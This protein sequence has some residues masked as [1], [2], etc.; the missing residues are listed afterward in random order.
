M[1]FAGCPIQ[2]REKYVEG[3]LEAF[4]NQTYP[5]KDIHMCFLVNDSIDG[6]LNKLIKYK[7]DHNFGKFTIIDLTG[8]GYTDKPGNRAINEYKQIARIRNIWLDRLNTETHI[9]SVDSDIIIPKNTLERLIAHKLDICSLL[10]NNSLQDGEAYNFIN[11][12][13][14]GL[15]VQRIRKPGVNPV[16]LTGAAYLINARVIR[17][18]VRYGGHRRGEDFY[19]CDMAHNLGFEVYCDMDLEGQH[20]MEDRNV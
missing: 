18:G 6:T 3:Y 7:E 17:A 16:F 14:R 15:L 19:F 12:N 8:F 1:I 11:Y 13:K 4:E 5:L 2:N 10:I 9:F 20:L